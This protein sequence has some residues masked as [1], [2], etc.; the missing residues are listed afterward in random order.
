MKIPN[1]FELTEYI[2][3]S[4]IVFM[5]THWKLGL[6]CGGS[7]EEGKKGNGGELH[8]E[9]IWN[10]ALRRVEKKESVLDCRSCE[11]W[12]G[13]GIPNTIQCMDSIEIRFKVQRRSLTI[14]VN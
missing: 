10:N 1:K 6:S 3:D 8:G 7:A 11:L 9:I 14:L 12:G 2:D 4:K 5:K 13:P